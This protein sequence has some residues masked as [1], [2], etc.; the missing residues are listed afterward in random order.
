MKNTDKKNRHRSFMWLMI[1]LL[2]IA[3]A[4]SV[5]FSGLMFSRSTRENREQIITNTA[6]LAAEQIDG[7]KVDGWLENGADEDYQKTAAMLQS[8]CNNT[9]YVQYVY[10]YKIKPDG[11]TVI[12]DMETQDKNLAEYTEVEDPAASLGETEEF[13][14]DFADYI[15]TL[16]KGGEID[17]IESNGSF[18]WL[19]TKY[20]PV[21]DSSGSCVAYVGVDVS[22]IGV[23]EY[24]KSFIMWNG[25]IS[26]LFLAI[27]ADIGYHFYSQMRKAHDYEE[28]ERRIKQQ[29]DLFEQTADALSGAIDAKDPYTNGH[30][31]RVAEYSLKIARAAGKSKEEC[32]DIYFAALLH[33]VGKIGVPESIINKKGKLTDKEFETVR[34]HPVLGAK[35]L[36]SIKGSAN[37]SIGAHYHHE[38]YDGNGYPDHLKG[39]E[40][41]EIARIISV[42]DT[43][44]AMTSLRSYRAPIPQQK[45]REEIVKCSGTQFDPKF[46]KIM[47]HLIDLDIEYKM[48]ERG[49]K[50][51]E[52]S[53]SDLV[54]D[55]HRSGVSDGIHL[56]NKLSVTDIKVS[57]YDSE[58]G[59]PARPSMILFDSL[60]GQI[61]SS[62]DEIKD[63]EY[64][65]YGE[66][67]FDGTTVV[68]GARKMQTTT[69]DK[70]GGKAGEFRIEAARVKDHAMIR[71][72]GEK[73][74]NEV[75]VAL[76]D[77]TRFSYISFTGE[78]CR[79]TDIKTENTDTEIT[80]DMIPR[81]A[82]EISYINEPAGDIPN[83]QVDGY[84]TDASQGVLVE[85]GM[86]ISFHAMSLPTARLVWHCP[87]LNLFGADDG[88]VFGENYRDYMLERLDGECWE[89]DPGCTVTSSNSRSGDF[90]SWDE[91]KARSKAGFDCTFTF[92]R[93][94]NIITVHTENGG[95]IV[96][97]VAKITDGNET[98]YAAI[99]GDQVALTNIRIKKPDKEQ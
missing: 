42:A 81:I 41:P 35:I 55:S 77:S 75:I 48:I 67:W 21:F 64:F 6:R 56:S 24:N 52:N 58:A 63:L 30:S 28:S 80:T 14:E 40:I 37:L 61:H 20:Q 98:V 86:E 12:F 95:V 5:V 49:E 44:D 97:A 84:R 2:I 27:L 99:T 23:S 57:P 51:K 29:H 60:D 22:M 45:V 73:Q 82:K 83:V 34:Q 13:D 71:I 91:W 43:Y 26:L 33:D 88:R 19:L 25:L 32:E 66:I 87:F 31:H 7:D 89:G 8:I 10:V 54:I 96:K 18:G 3:F 93:K 46:A 76:P 36:E 74:T 1:A 85:D 78:H 38:R 50:N 15:P 16:L 59:L 65:E 4:A 69:T 68:S 47:L 53:G 79:I 72:T 94:D 17:T 90:V 9:P 11:C 70:G 39:E 62:E 92:E